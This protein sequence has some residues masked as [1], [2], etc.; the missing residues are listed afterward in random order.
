MKIITI[1]DKAYNLT[2]FENLYIRKPKYENTN[3][4]I[5]L[6]SFYG[7]EKPQGS[8]NNDF[9]YLSLKSNFYETHNTERHGSDLH[10]QKAILANTVLT[11]ATRKT[12]TYRYSQISIPGILHFFDHF[13]YN[14]T[15]HKLLMKDYLPII[16]K[17][18]HLFFKKD[19]HS[20]SYSRGISAFDT[21]VYEEIEDFY[22]EA[23]IIFW[24]KIQH[25]F[26]PTE[27]F[28]KDELVFSF[29]NKGIFNKLKDSIIN[30]INGEIFNISPFINFGNHTP[31]VS[32][33]RSQNAW[34]RSGHFSPDSN[35]NSKHFL[36]VRP[37]LDITF[38]EAINFSECANFYSSNSNP[39]LFNTN[40]VSY[41]LSKHPKRRFD[42]IKVP[43][44]K[45]L[46]SDST[47]ELASYTKSQV[48][49]RRICFAGIVYNYEILTDEGIPAFVRYFSLITNNHSRP[50]DSS[51]RSANRWIEFVK[52]IMFKN[53][54]GIL[55]PKMACHL[56]KLALKDLDK[57]NSS[58]LSSMMEEEIQELSTIQDQ[59]Y[60]PLSSNQNNSLNLT[61]SINSKLTERYEKLSQKI[62]L[63]KKSLLLSD[64]TAH[65]LVRKSN[66][67]ITYQ[68]AYEKCQE[69][70]QDLINTLYSQILD[71]RNAALYLQKNNPLYASIQSKYIKEYNDS[72]SNQAFLSDPFFENLAKD[73]IKIL[74]LSYTSGETEKNTSFTIS[75]EDS[76]EK[77]IKL[78]FNEHKISE[79]TFLIDR[80]VLIQ[81]DSSN[82]HVVGG[83]YVIH[84]NKD[85]LQLK[86]ASKTSVFGKKDSQYLIHPHSSST[87]SIS[88][89]FKYSTACLG[90]AA[91]LLWNA[92][93]ENNL[94]LII[95]SAMTWVSSAN[96]S[97]SWGKRYT[98]FPFKQDLNLDSTIIETTSEI[99]EKDVEDFL[100]QFCE[101]DLAFSWEDAFIK[102]P[103]EVP[104]AEEE[105]AEP[106]Y[107]P[108][109]SAEDTELQPEE[110]LPASLLENTVENVPSSN[111]SRY[112]SEE[113]DC[114][115]LNY[116]P[117]QT[118]PNLE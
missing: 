25:K 58:V 22:N 32:L 42:V 1:V 40:M 111:S 64:E 109:P 50:L 24:K 71:C 101:N 63:N 118:Q 103:I 83:P 5:P 87:S 45:S 75:S 15:R 34:R 33:T 38:A 86:L 39:D 57:Y 74:S 65:T 14:F 69:E 29:F 116:E 18:P 26:I 114:P 54:V 37:F 35:S 117:Y 62:S 90:E 49:A 13:Q 82:K 100:I 23:I 113:F 105:C 91:A 28:L 16:I 55:N 115:Q 56:Q 36:H 78:S 79:L 10:C 104:I 96:S 67:I 59:A 81:I 48:L 7:L 27:G 93:K 21:E 108:L 107:A 43:G 70:Q 97:D 98:A 76:I 52:K 106:I 41:L 80:P 77:F 110:S 95:L 102:V 61:P 85:R 89:L 30:N 44:W 20:D 112:V 72:L 19:F 12:N 88:S 47:I 84:C 11:Q 17:T 3:D 2:H 4:S 68:R 53:S 66:D 31:D 99:S 46:S 92:F 94:K 8:W 6:E 73:N 60:T 51:S 9:R